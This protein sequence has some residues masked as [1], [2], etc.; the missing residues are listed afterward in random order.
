MGYV[1]YDSAGHGAQKT[2]GYRTRKCLL[3]RL[4]TSSGCRNAR[5]QLPPSRDGKS[6]FF[7]WNDDSTTRRSDP[8]RQTR[9]PWLVALPMLRDAAQ[10]SAAGSG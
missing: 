2:G 1:V 8:A 3:Y 4:G 7:D 10:P 6:R 5:P 9:E